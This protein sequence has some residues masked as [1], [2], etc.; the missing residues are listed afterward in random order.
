MVIS[1]WHFG[2]QCTGT[3]NIKCTVATTY[4]L[5]W[6]PFLA[7]IINTCFLNTWTQTDKWC[8]IKQI[9]LT[10]RAH[11]KAVINK[12]FS[13]KVLSAME[14]VI[15]HDFKITLID[16]DPQATKNIWMGRGERIHLAWFDISSLNTLDWLKCPSNKEL[17]G[18]LEHWAHKWLHAWHQKSL[19]L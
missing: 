3:Q 2:R 12:F 14:H 11:Y 19:D 4:S 1:G 7:G 10:S 17:G 18:L 13:P 15:L 9:W 8:L 16:L 5:P 6:Y